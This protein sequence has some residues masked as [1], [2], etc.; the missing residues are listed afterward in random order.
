MTH[1]AVKILQIETLDH[2]ICLSERSDKS[3]AIAKSDPLGRGL[4]TVREAGYR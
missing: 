2:V 4:F 1:E 3:L